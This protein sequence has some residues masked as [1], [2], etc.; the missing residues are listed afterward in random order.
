VIVGATA[1]EVSGL[2]V[3]VDCAILAHFLGNAEI[4][5]EVFFLEAGGRISK[6]DVA[7][8]C[9]DTC[10]GR[11]VGSSSTC[12]S[13]TTGFCNANSSRLVSLVPGW[14]RVIRFLF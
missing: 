3:I 9:C 2:D 7:A 11:V 13:T 4:G 14:L 1:E 10:F 8:K 6:I 12:S 5:A